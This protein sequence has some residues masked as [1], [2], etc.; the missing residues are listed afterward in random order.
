MRVIVPLQGVVQGRGGLFWGSVIPC[1]LFYFLQLYFKRRHRSHPHSPPPSPSP[2]ATSS[3]PRSPPT[4]SDKLTEVSVLPRSLSRIHLP[5][6]GASSAPYVSAR[7]NSVAKAGDSPYFLGL[8]KVAEDSYHQIGNPNG[9]IQLGLAENKVS[10][11][12]VCFYVDWVLFLF[13]WF[14]LLVTTNELVEFLA[15]CSYLWTWFEI[16]LRRMR[17]VLYW[18]DEEIPGS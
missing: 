9:V 16:G 13:Q 18:G 2:D 1:A 6:R 14:G 17:A 7:A 5:P 12:L 15:G 4:S 8:R 3:P 10:A 11:I